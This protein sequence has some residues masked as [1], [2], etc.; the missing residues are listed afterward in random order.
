MRTQDSRNPSGSRCP[1]RAAIKLLVLVCVCGLSA[2]CTVEPPAWKTVFEAGEKKKTDLRFIK[3]GEPAITSADELVIYLDTSG[4]MAGYVAPDGQTIFGQTLQQLRI[5]AGT[6]FNDA[7]VRVLVRSVDSVVGPPLPEGELSTASQNQGFYRGGETNLAGAISLLGRGLSDQSTAPARFSI[8]VTDGVQ[9]TNARNDSHGCAAGSDQFCVNQKIREL[10]DKGWG[11]CVLGVRSDFRGKIYSEVNRN[12]SIAYQTRDSEPSKFRPFYLYLFSPERKSLD[13]LVK[14]I[15]DRLRAI[16]PKDDS[17]RQL[18]LTS[19]YAEG[20]TIAELTIPQSSAGELKKGSQRSVEMA[21]PRFTLIVNL[22]TAKSGPKPFNISLKIPWSNQALDTAPS[23]ELAR[24]MRWEVIPV[25]PEMVNQ[26]ERYVEVKI[27]K[28]V[29]EA[30]G[31]STLLLSAGW[32]PGTAER[33][34][35]AYL[36]VGRLDLEKANPSWIQQWST[37]LDTST[38]AANRTFE[39]EKALLS[40][41]KNP[42]LEKQVICESYLL[43]GSE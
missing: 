29:V 33:Q 16:V 24:I 7:P 35:R 32:P 31:T 34:W 21:P 18:N 41:W 15:K 2:A 30:D 42:I 40:L 38:N 39:I 43:V 13:K 17:L 11:V 19:A 23:Q 28:Q 22:E 20:E 12:Q 9:S 3:G 26:S 1:L 25:W 8:L 4:S 5:V 6:T 36:L 14:A 10:L 27:A 37:N